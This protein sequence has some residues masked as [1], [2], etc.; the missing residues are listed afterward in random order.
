[1]QIYICNNISVIFISFL[2]V[3]T[4]TILQ[5]W[6]V[7]DLVDYNLKASYKYMHIT[8]LIRRIKDIWKI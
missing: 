5:L 3:Y 7:R 6:Y 8:E 2:T 4:S 1:M